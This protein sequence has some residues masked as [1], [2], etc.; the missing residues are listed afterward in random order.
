MTEQVCEGCRWWE[1]DQHAI[2]VCFRHVP[3]GNLGAPKTH[4]TDRCGEWSDAS[5]TQ[6]Q[7]DR[8]KL[9]RQFAQALLAAGMP[10]DDTTWDEAA[11]F[12]MAEH[13]MLWRLRGEKGRNN[14]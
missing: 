3:M 8:Q 10:V 6:E 1:N 4:S 12:A 11:R 13:T 2:G 7:E 14:K 5:I 9:T